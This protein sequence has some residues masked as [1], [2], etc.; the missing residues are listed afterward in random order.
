MI[1][2]FLH[3]GQISVLTLNYDSTDSI[4]ENS[5][6]LLSIKE[7]D[8]ASRFRFENDRQEFLKRRIFLREVLAGITGLPMGSIELSEDMHGKPMCSQLSIELNCFFS[9]SSS[10]NLAVIAI[11]NGYELGVDIQHIPIHYELNDLPGHLF[12]E[13]ERK[14]ISS[15]VEPEKVLCKI[16]TKKEA[17]AK[18]TGSGLKFEELDLID[19]TPSDFIHVPS[20][21]FDEKLLVQSFAIQEEFSSAVAIKNFPDTHADILVYA[22]NTLAVTI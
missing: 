15:S 16:W 18:L 5:L 2:P 8:R 22:W 13:N 14:V 9:C 17:I 7:R 20:A 3:V 1:Q 12:S 10:N 19:T 21:L 6:N 11:A 4:I